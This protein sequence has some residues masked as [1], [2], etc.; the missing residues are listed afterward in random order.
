MVS[1]VELEV[2]PDAFLLLMYFSLFN[3][4]H[5]LVSV[6]SPPLVE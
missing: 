2:N 5:K 1:Y 3:G 4:Q 6:K